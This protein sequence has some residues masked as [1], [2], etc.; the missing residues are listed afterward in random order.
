ME[1][2]NIMEIYFN[3]VRNTLNHVGITVKTYKNRM[4]LS[5]MKINKGGISDSPYPPI[6]NEDLKRKIRK[7]DNYKCGVCLNWG[8]TIHHIDYNENNCDETNL[9]NLCSTCHPRIH[10]YYIDKEF[11]QEFFVKIINEKYLILKN[12]KGGMNES[13]I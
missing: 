7:R 5:F 1:M 13:S 11:W 10:N 8:N 9:I 6:F 3:M 2:K 4:N 12:L